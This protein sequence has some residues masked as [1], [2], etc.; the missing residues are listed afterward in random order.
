[1]LYFAYGSNMCTKRLQKRVPSATKMNNATKAGYSLHFHKK[2]T[3]GSGKCNI[4]PEKDSMVHGIVFDI[5]PVEKIGLDRIEGLNSGYEE[6]HITVKTGTKLVNVYTYMASENYIDNTLAP[7]S[8]YKTH[9]IEGAKEHGL[10]KEYI[11]EIQKVVS[12]KDQNEERRNRELS[13]FQ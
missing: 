10:P 2:S 7:Y 13:I 1:M 5:D 3:D 4:V 12:K 8:W 6:I 11:S 9:V